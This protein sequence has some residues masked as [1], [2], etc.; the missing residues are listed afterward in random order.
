MCRT[1]RETLQQAYA[2]VILPDKK[3]EKSL[4]ALCTEQKQAGCRYVLLERFTGSRIRNEH[5][6]F[7]MIM[8][9][10]L[11]DTDGNLLTMQ[12]TSASTKDLTPI[13]A[14]VYLQFQA[15]EQR[16]KFLR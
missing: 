6:N 4:A 1:L 11:Y 14:M 13:E 2:P 7:H 3:E 16:D 15:K 5:N 12:T 8:E 10:E 9:E